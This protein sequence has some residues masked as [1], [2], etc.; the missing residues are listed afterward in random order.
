MGDSWTDALKQPVVVRTNPNDYV[1]QDLSPEIQEKLVKF[2][3]ITN[4]IKRELV[5]AYLKHG[6]RDF[7]STHEAYAVLLEEVDELWDEVKKNTGKTP[8][9]YTEAVQIA[10]MAYKYIISF[11]KVKE[12]LELTIVKNKAGL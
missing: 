2:D 7:V 10:A 3:A 5:S 12:P 6:T 11:D 8:E 1:K 4:L 9:A